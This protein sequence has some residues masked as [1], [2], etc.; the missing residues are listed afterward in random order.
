MFTWGVEGDT[1][2]GT[3][4]VFA[5]NTIVND[6]SGGAGILNRTGVSIGFTG[7]QVYGLSEARLSNGPLDESGTVF[8]A[9][10][11]SLDT[12]SLSFINP[13]AG[14]PPPPDPTPPPSPPPPSPPPPDPPPAPPP[15][16]DISAWQQLVA[17]DFVAYATAHPA[18]YNDPNA[19]T[20]LGIEFTD[21]LAG[22]GGVPAAALWGPFPT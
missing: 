13:L 5:N 7:N 20:A 8:L 4:V 12:S 22:T 16:I 18:V 14:S 17:T 19:I 11:P 10:R 21:P 15:V 3:S 6:L 9:S 1:N 2:P